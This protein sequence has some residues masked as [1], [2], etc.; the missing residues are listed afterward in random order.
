MA[1]EHENVFFRPTHYNVRR[2]RVG[3][4]SA[5][6]P[7]VLRQQQPASKD[8]L[9]EITICD[10][11]R[12]NEILLEKITKIR[13]PLI[14][15]IAFFLI[16]GIMNSNFFSVISQY[17]SIAASIHYSSIF[18]FDEQFSDERDFLSTKW[19]FAVNLFIIF[20]V[21]ECLRGKARTL[22]LSNSSLKRQLRVLKATYQPE[23][24]QVIE[25][26]QLAIA[27]CPKCARPARVLP[28]STILVT[29]GECGEKW[30]SGPTASIE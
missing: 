13:R 24:Q 3:S 9:P 27:E 14:G 20:A 4:G 26:F 23:Y 18:P 28:K 10:E 11:I 5:S 30:T 29:C 15:A 17:E 7:Q 12:K 19:F 6:G 16:F 8:Q 21:N 25:R 1:E 22:R 2:G